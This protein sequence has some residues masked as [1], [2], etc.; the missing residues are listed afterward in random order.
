MSWVY[1]M[2]L[3][4]DASQKDMVHIIL[5][6]TEKK[7]DYNQPG[8]NRELLQEVVTFLEKEG[9][10]KEE[11]LGIAVVLGAGGKVTGFDGEKID[12]ME[13]K[14]LMSSDESLHSS[15]LALISSK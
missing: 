8:K 12:V 2:F 10:K 5:F 15:L 11:I 9:C 7:A 14:V 6:D 1:N 3:V 4:F 13:P